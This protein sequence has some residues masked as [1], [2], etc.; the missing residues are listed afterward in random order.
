MNP[1]HPLPT[2]LDS[3]SA[4]P[5][6]PFRRGRGK[7]QRRQQSLLLALLLRAAAPLSALALPAAGVAWMLTAPPFALASVEVSGNARVTSEWVRSELAPLAGENLLRLPLWQVEARILP[8]PWVAAVTIHKRLPNRIEVE[9]SE[10]QPAA[11]VVRDGALWWSDAEGRLIDRLA[12]SEPPPPLPRLVEAGIGARGE[13]SSSPGVP[14]AL[15]ALSDLSEVAP[16]W[17]AELSEARLLSRDEL[18]I[19]TGALEFPLRIR[20]GQVKNKVRALQRIL[21]E[22]RNRYARLDA[23]D[24]RFSRRIVVSPTSPKDLA[25]LEAAERAKAAAAAEEDAAGEEPLVEG[26]PGDLVQ[27][28]EHQLSD[29]S[30]GTRNLNGRTWPASSIAA[31]REV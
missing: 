31:A 22:I 14:T 13:A 24:L 3:P 20:A 21:P 9:V 7:I 25:A 5:V 12:A 16:G 23:I 18:E 6:A 28:D 27:P 8:N 26:D 4:P 17:A 1:A 29:L 19:S 11:V 15:A 30:T 2:A 10:R